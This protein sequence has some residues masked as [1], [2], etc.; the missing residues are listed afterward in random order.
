MISVGLYNFNQISFQQLKGHVAR[1][2]VYKF[3]LAFQIRHFWGTF[4]QRPEKS[5]RC[6]KLFHYLT[7]N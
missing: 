2:M 6:E 5:K 7:V 4:L 3:Q 1:F